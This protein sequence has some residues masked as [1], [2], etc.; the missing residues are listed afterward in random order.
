MG[1]PR[2]ILAAVLALWGLLA[3]KAPSAAAE[4]AFT[5]VTETVDLAPLENGAEIYAHARAAAWL[6][7]LRRASGFLLDRRELLIADISSEDRL[8]LAAQLYTADVWS[9]AG[10]NQSLRLTVTL[11][12]KPEAGLI[13]ARTLRNPEARL[14]RR[15]LLD[16]VSAA[17]EAEAGNGER[18]TTEKLLDGLWLAQ[19]AMELTAE[20]WYVEPQALSDMERAVSLAPQSALAHLLLGETRLRSG[21]PQQCAQACD[22]AL[23]LDSSLRRARYIRALAHWRLQQFALAEDDL[24]ASLADAPPGEERIQRLQARGAVRMLRGKYDGMCEDYMAACSLGD[25]DGLKT[26]RE[27]GCCKAEGAR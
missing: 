22:A 17:L 21:L 15:R 4:T 8:A 6:A 16:E 26:L 1:A 7:A 20:G 13:L 10:P 14:L 12:P 3:E 19:N 23:R 18:G 25:C 11:H 24:N 2:F 9:L 5:P 27:Q